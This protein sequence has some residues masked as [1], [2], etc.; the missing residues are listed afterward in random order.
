ML[1]VT[2]DMYRVHHSIV[3]QETNSNFGFNLSWWDRI[4]GTYCPQPAAGHEPMVIGKGATKRGLRSLRTSPKSASNLR[5][6]GGAREIRNVGV[7]GFELAEKMPIS[8]ATFG[9]S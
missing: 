3:V 1:L 8:R 7:T 4:L 2:L 9:M 6:G 5:L